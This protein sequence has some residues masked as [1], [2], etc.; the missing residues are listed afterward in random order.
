MIDRTKERYFVHGRSQ[1]NA[2]KNSSANCSVS[3]LGRNICSNLRVKHLAALET[4]LRYFS[5]AFSERPTLLHGRMTFSLVVEYLLNCMFNKRIS[6]LFG[7]SLQTPLKPTLPLILPLMVWKRWSEITTED[8]TPDRLSHGNTLALLKGS[9]HNSWMQPTWLQWG[10]TCGFSLIA[11]FSIA[12]WFRA[13][14]LLFSEG[15]CW[16]HSSNCRVYFRLKL[17]HPLTNQKSF[18]AYVNR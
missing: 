4:A 12:L 13:F 5:M 16:K 2:I 15:V 6:A 9:R 7:A 10:Y 8:Q 18:L 17:F 1:I 3:F 14:H 11:R